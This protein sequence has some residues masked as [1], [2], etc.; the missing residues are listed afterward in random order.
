MMRL[1]FSASTRTTRS[2]AAGAELPLSEAELKGFSSSEE[3]LRGAGLG[4]LPS[5]SS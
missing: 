2:A 4:L 1:R 3:A 5:G